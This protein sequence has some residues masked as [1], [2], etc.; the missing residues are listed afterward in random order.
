[1]VRGWND[2]RN[3]VSVRLADAAKQRE[4]RVRVYPAIIPAQCLNISVL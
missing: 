4:L 2:P 1:M 3:R